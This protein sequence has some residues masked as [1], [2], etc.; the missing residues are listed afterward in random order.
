M[1][2]PTSAQIIAARD[3]EGLKDRARALGAL[4]GMTPGEI[5]AAWPSIVVAP[6]DQSGESSIASVLA[7]T[8][9]VYDQAVAALPPE[10]GVNPSAVTDAQ[11][12]YAVTR[13]GGHATE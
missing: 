12:L 4:V 8:Q 7:Y 9:A 5:D 2:V 11:I 1:T 10:P 3:N 6:V 13:R